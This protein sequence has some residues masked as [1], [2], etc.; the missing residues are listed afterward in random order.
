MADEGPQYKF[1]RFPRTIDDPPR[2]AFWAVDELMVMGSVVFVG[3][4][5]RY[6]LTSILVAWVIQKLY[7]KFRDGK[8]QGWATHIS[9]WFGM[10]FRQRPTLPNSFE[11]KFTP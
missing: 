3:M 11:R 9:Y 6:L 5:M 10:P 7:S 4:F 1:K 8:P 2:Y